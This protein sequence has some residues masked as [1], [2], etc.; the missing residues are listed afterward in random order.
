M[1]FFEIV[2]IMFGALFYA[3]L[4]TIVFMG[5]LFVLLRA[6]DKR[7]VGTIPFFIVGIFLAIFL[8]VQQTLMFGA[9]K[10]RSA[11]SE[12]KETVNVCTDAMQNR[13]AALSEVFPEG[14][15]LNPEELVSK[16][17]E[18]CQILVT[19]GDILDLKTEDFTTAIDGEGSISENLFQMVDDKLKTY[20]WHR[21]WWIIG[22]SLLS[23]IVVLLLPGK[24]T[25]YGGGRYSSD[26]GS[27]G[28][29]SSE[30]GD[31]GF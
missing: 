6:I 21:V 13:M 27:Y 26:D 10:A 5:L 11:V 22:I 9:I 7:H 20:I 25:S 29:T 4:A 14:K 17:Q 8:L 12:I 3:L 30:V 19:Y 1:M 24:K 16:A 28:S 31:W 23:C 2:S 15:S 18:D